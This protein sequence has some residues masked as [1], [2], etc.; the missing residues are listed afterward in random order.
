[1]VNSKPDLH[2]RNDAVD[3]HLHRLGPQTDRDIV[4]VPG[5]GASPLPFWSRP[6]RSLAGDLRARGWTPWTVDFQVSWR[7]RG[8]RADTLLHAL[9]VA[10]ATLERREDGPRQPVDAIGHSLGG[11]LLLAMAAEGLALRRIVTLGSGLDYRLGR[12]PLPR[13]LSLAPKGLPAV[14][15]KL[16]RG[17]LPLTRLARLGAPLFGRGL[18]LPVE[19]EQFH[20][21]TT[22]GAVVRDVLRRGVRDLP[23][24]L[25]LDLAALFSERGL[26]V[27]NKDLP[28]RE[29]VSAITAPLL[30]VAG[31]QDRQCPVGSVRAAVTHIPSAQLLEVGATGAGYGHV[32]LLTGRCADRDVFDPVLAFLAQPELE[33]D[34]ELQA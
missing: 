1:V 9:E 23:L 15:L 19:R 28:I 33:R 20:P 7:G 8:Q 34:K 12:S 11:I 16:D 32:D 22:E 3:V 2:V 6:G 10:V 5:L 18:G 13:L 31:R 30:M 14:R 29:A 24:P 17:G 25:L 26:H 4:L 27:G 21:G